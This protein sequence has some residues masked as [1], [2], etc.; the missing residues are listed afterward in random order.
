M[1]NCP[2]VLFL[3]LF[4]FAK[5]DTDGQLSI[6]HHS[7][8]SSLSPNTPHID[9]NPPNLSS[10]R[11]EINGNLWVLRFCRPMT[12][13]ASKYATTIMQTQKEDIRDN[14]IMAAQTLFARKGYLKTS[15]RDIAGAAGVGIG[16]MYN[17]FSSKDELF[18]A[19]VRPVL[20]QFETMVQR[21]HGDHGRDAM[22][23]TNENYWHE[24]INEYISLIS[25]HCALMKILLLKA[26]GSSLEDY[27]RQFTDRATILVRKW[28]DDNKKRYPE[29]NI[30]VSD[31]SIHL[32][33]VWMFALF[34]EIIM[35]DVKPLE[36]RKIVEEYVGFEI[37]GWKYILKIQ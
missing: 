33:T 15:M 6:L 36:I 30:N 4:F 34:E 26:Q 29:I 13:F 35:H 23:M 9:A 27:R 18:R 22:S 25:K 28:F 16:N 21:H 24:V 32:H 2:G 8:P 5:Q 1:I 17:Y 37:N 10:D 20:E 19:V 7:L 31:F 12:I 3:L 11:V 14:I